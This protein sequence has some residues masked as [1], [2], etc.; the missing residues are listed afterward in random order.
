M[1]EIGHSRVP[2]TIAAEPSGKWLA[3]AA[4]HTETL[5]RL[6]PCP[7]MPKGVYRYASHAGMNRHADE[8]LAAGMALLA[9]ARLAR[10]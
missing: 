7:L 3:G 8:A 5:A 1:R 6:G 2:D 4:R 10:D 9:A